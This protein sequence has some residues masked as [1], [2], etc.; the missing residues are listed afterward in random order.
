M[1]PGDHEKI[2][3][4][5]IASIFGI[6]HTP[7]KPCNKKI[8]AHVFSVTNTTAVPKNL[9]IAPTTLL[10]IAGNASAAFLARLL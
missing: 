7:N 8:E 6:S 5:L 10:K 2:V 3:C 4:L 1:T 9:K